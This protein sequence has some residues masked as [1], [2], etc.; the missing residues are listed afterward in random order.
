[1][2]KIINSVNTS[3]NPRLNYV[4]FHILIKEKMQKLNLCTVY[5]NKIFHK[6]HYPSRWDLNLDCWLSGHAVQESHLDAT[7]EESF[8][9]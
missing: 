4:Y 5:Q 9:M 7:L 8:A 1:M 2:A 6:W 3:A